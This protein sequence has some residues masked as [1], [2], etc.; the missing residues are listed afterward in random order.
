[1]LAHPSVLEVLSDIIHCIVAV[2]EVHWCPW[3]LWTKE[4]VNAVSA[5]HV[6]MLASTL[7]IFDVIQ[8]LE[9]CPPPQTK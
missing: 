7:I 1:M 9:M 3:L 5:A 2:A 8:K 4:N 6:G